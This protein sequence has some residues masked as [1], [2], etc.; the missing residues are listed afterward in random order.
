VGVHQ[1]VEASRVFSPRLKE[2][3][4]RWENVLAPRAFSGPSFFLLPPVL[5][6]LRSIRSYAQGYRMATQDSSDVH[7]A[8]RVPP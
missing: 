2:A 8:T 5:R 4:Q 3:R 7:L 6:C 1:P